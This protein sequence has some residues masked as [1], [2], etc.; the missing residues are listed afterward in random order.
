MSFKSVIDRV[1]KSD[2]LVFTFLRSIASSQAASWIDL[3][4]GFILFSLIGL[5]PWLATACG[6]VAGGIVN[7]IINYRFTF[8]AKGCPW[9]AV[10]VKYFIVWVGSLTLNSL[11]TQ[12]LTSL[13]EN[14]TWLQD[15]GFSPDAAYAVGRVTASLLVSWFW[16]FLLQRHFVYRPTRFDHYAVDAFAFITRKKKTQSCAGSSN[17]KETI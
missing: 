2:S 5:Q 17:N 12:A 14:W 7:C 4:L 16:N 9:A 10:V 11:G 13:L 15:L 3:G 8:H 6:A 1:L